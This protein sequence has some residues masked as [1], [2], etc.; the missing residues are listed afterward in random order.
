MQSDQ[1]LC[2]SLLDLKFLSIFPGL[3][4]SQLLKRSVKVLPTQKFHNFS[5]DMIH[6]VLVMKKI[7]VFEAIRKEEYANESASS[8]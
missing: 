2:C 4:W 1:H 8:G 5:C 6:V 3:C 7:A